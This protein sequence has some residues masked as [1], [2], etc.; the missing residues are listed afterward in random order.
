MKHILKIIIILVLLSQLNYSQKS[1]IFGTIT[2]DGLLEKVN[3]S[4]DKNSAFAIS[5]RNGQYTIR[6]LDMGSYDLVFTHIGY[7]KKLVSIEIE[8]D[9]KYEIDIQLEKSLIQ[10]GEAQVVSSR[11]EQIVKDI[12]LPIE[13][14]SKT[15]LN[16]TTHLT[17]SDLLNKE[18]GLS[19]V[20][21]GPWAT[22][23]NVRGL[24]KQNIVY[25]IDGNRIE[26]STNI[27]AGL[28]LMDMNDLE[29]IEIVKGGL[30]SL[31]GT[32]AT[33][34]VINIISKEAK[35]N[36]HTYVSSQ[37]I[38]GFNSVNNGYSNYLNMKAG[39]YNWSAKVTGS[40]RKVDDTQ[41]PSGTLENSS[42]QDESLNASL[43]Y[44][45]ID[46]LQ[47][48]FDYQKFSAY[49]VGIP[50]GTPFPK[51]AMA[52]YKYANRELF[53]GSLQL[54]N[55]SNKFLKASIKYYHQV[56]GRSV[57]IKPNAMVTA[58]PRADHT[59]NG[60]SFQSDWYLSKQN[61]LIVGIDVWERQY[62]GMRKVTNLAKD[63]ISVDKPI[64]NS[65]FR[66]LGMFAKDDINLFNNSLN[67]S[68]SG[69]YD[70]INITNQETK[71]PVYIINAG[72]RNDN[73]RNDL[74]SFEAYDETNKSVSGGFGAV[75]KF[76]NEY[77]IVLNLGYNFRSPSL[78]ERYQYID[79]GG[80]VY[81][82]NPELKPEEG[83]FFDLGF[84]IWKD[85]LNIRFN[86]FLNSFSNLVID[87]ILFKDSIYVKNNVGDARLYGFDGRIDYNIYEDFLLYSSIA[88]V[89][90]E[91]LTQN[92]DL[93]QISPL[94][95]TLGFIVPIKN[96][97]QMDFSAT[98]ASDQN[99]IGIG[100]RR[101]GGFVYF[102]ISLASETINFS[103]VNLKLVAG[104]QNLFNRSYREH[105]S[106]YRGISIVE[107][108]R[109]IFA[110]FIIDFE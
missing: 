13:Y 51:S 103:F 102:D 3:I 4:I 73:V 91:D 12:S 63:I 64:P 17:L 86:T 10:L 83:L 104:I 1:I 92:N 2:G 110:K 8:A 55:I 25:L 100:E 75:Y 72:I 29:S 33:G 54:N 81:L 58:N 27:A 80:I 74:A 40:F 70:F 50:G 5:D 61:Y 15:K 85:N 16:N 62:E 69:R 66:S 20:K 38:S 107:P 95:G 90:G 43:K 106:T 57:E 56:I 65:K 7:K 60:L 44:V 36:D 39:N 35:F 22:T 109:N 77:D 99:K 84:R 98:L 28:S 42:F 48:N 32:G 41:I 11:S 37:F 52:K 53:S 45:P 31:Y 79:L 101:T 6:N 96:I 71:N 14:V 19:V 26:T 88:Y 67:I 59:T 9:K 105:L 47:L 93:P 87:D 21:D 78:E 68:L 46:N 97:L 89:R 94:N 82:G 24:S 108:G 76:T 30:S 18:T 34:G 49:D 23:I